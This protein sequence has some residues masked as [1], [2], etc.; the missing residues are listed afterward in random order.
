[1]HIRNLFL[2][3][4]P[5]YF[6]SVPLIAAIVVFYGLTSMREPAPA[7]GTVSTVQTAGCISSMNI[8]RL[9]DFSLTRP[10]LL[11]DVNCESD[12]LELTKEAVVDVIHQQ[13]QLG[14]V[15][16]VSVYLRKFSDGS[17]ITINGNEQYSPG[18]LMK[19]PIM[20]ACLK[21]AENNPSLL[22]K[23]LVFTGHKEANMPHQNFIEDSLVAGKKYSIRE[24]LKRMIVDSDNDATALLSSNL[25]IA[26]VKK[27]FN[28][29]NLNEPEV[30]QKDYLITAFDCAKFLRILFN[31]SYLSHN[32]SE[33]AL[34]LLIQSKFKSGI[35]KGMPEGMKVAHKFGES[36]ETGKEVQL[37]EEAIVYAD[38]NPYLL[39]IMTKGNDFTKLSESISGIS[40]AVYDKFSGT[41]LN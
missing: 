41:T 3:K 38:G 18:S 36:G 37:H 15:A 35:I 2:A 9:K 8:V 16:A 31:S 17:W 30:K 21:Q 5:F 14:N 24:L 28:D 19:V 26:M 10:I 33:F 12:G 20:I 4:I 27:L 40:K 22:E 29:L 32:M 39:V 6:F 11:S 1:M 34:D 13:Q 25:D 23:Q 7:I